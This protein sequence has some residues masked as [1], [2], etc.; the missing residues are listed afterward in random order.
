MF[1]PQA[2]LLDATQCQCEISVPD[3]TS[4]QERKED[5]PRYLSHISVFYYTLGFVR[6]CQ[7]GDITSRTLGEKMMPTLSQV[8]QVTL[9]LGDKNRLESSTAMGI[10]PFL[11][12]YLRRIY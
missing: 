4:I 10:I 12:Q 7:D 9:Q 5:L 6:F 8:K 2:A 3:I 1:L 11:S